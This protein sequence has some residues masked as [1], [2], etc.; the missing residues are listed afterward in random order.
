MVQ[1]HHRLPTHPLL[2]IL[3]TG[4]L[5]FML[6]GPLTRQLSDAISFGLLWLYESTGFLGGLVFG[7]LYSPIVVTGL[8][9]SFPALG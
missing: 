5:T 9:Q 8:H 3:I 2:T 1:G 6:V 7:L 4:F